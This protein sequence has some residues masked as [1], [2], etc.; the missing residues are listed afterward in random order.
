MRKAGIFESKKKVTLILFIALLALTAAAVLLAVFAMPSKDV[1]IVSAV[2]GMFVQKPEVVETIEPIPGWTPVA[3]IPRPESF[4]RPQ[5][6][7]AIYLKPGEDF[8]ISGSESAE[9]I[10]SQIDSAIAFAKEKTMNTIVIDP[11]IGGNVIYDSEIFEKTELPMDVIGYIS[12]KCIENDM[13]V[14]S[15]YYVLPDEITG[16]LVSEGQISTDLVNRIKSGADAFARSC[17]INGVLLDSYFLM[18][19]FDRYDEYLEN[20]AGIG[21]E[22]YMYN[23]SDTLFSDVVDIFS[24]VAPDMEIGLISEAVWAN[25]TENDEGSETKSSFTMFGTGHCDVKGYIEK[26]LVD[27]VSVRAYEATTSAVVPYSAV[28]DWWSGIA[29]GSGLPLYMIHAANKVGTSE[30]GWG[31]YDQLPKQIIEARRH[32][33]FSGSIFNSMTWLRNDPMESVSK[34]IDYYG[35]AI[36][37]DTILKELALTKPASLT[38]TTL[39]PIVT[40]AGASDPNVEVTLNGEPIEIDENGYFSITEDLDPGLNKFSFFNK[41]KTITYNITRKIEVLRPES[42]GPLGTVVVDGGTQVTIST[43]AYKDST[44]YAV[45][46]GIRVNLTA[47][48]FQDDST[49]TESEYRNYSGTFTAP[50][51]T[52]AEQNLGSIK[53]YGTWTWSGN[54]TATF[55]A[56]QTLGSVKV[57]KKVMLADG[58]PIVVIADAAETYPTDVIN[59]I[60]DPS[61]FPLAKG[62]IDV[63]VGNEI[64]YNDGNKTFSYYNLASGVRVYSK[65]IAPLPVDQKPGGNQI[66]GYSV[67]AD[68]RYT[69]V[70]I[71]MNQKVSYSLKYDGDAV[72]IRFNYT[73]S[74]PGSMQLNSNPLFGQA[75]WNGTTLRLQLL[76]RNVFMGYRAWYDNNGNLV[77][78]FNNPPRVSGTDLTG[79]TI[80]VDPGHGG[81][82]PGTLGFLAAY[83]EKVVNELMATELASELAARGA[84][85]VKLNTYSNNVTMEE[86]LRQAR[87]ISPH[88][89]ISLHGNSAMRSSGLGTE[90]YY[91]NNYSYDI[92]NR[93]S[94]HV[95]SAMETTN[96]GAKWGLY[97]V[98]R[99]SQFPAVLCE[100]GFLSNQGE[101]Y[102]LINQHYQVSVAQG[103][104]NAVSSYLQAM[105]PGSSATGTQ[106]YGG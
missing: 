56:E 104:A 70:T 17:D 93:M 78:Q 57:N 58:R 48:D 65:D 50:A 3:K 82:D 80:V 94:S 87:S 91:F 69:N 101:Y 86:R 100:V 11:K 13:Y 21:Y 60:S 10:M 42:S 35:G 16:K 23:I 1:W 49:N 61:F 71:S 90:V 106:T 75:D 84:N 19:K 9:E 66:T 18:D 55:S 52:E 34:L 73:D 46:G 103:I 33:G 32:E 39:E 68:G 38:F 88:L 36:R 76:R 51:A 44:V 96:R 12:Q 31:Q 15:I 45:I 29:K 41:G 30:A 74:A 20:G 22:N 98:T 81:N 72:N 89:Y 67:S 28:V 4:S 92:A 85:V 97:Y 83:S 8:F 64:L 53:L 63:A 95:A 37:P 40:F 26:G 6:M 7:R 77:F 24:Q 99:E 105:T 14:Y 102:K 54:S 59:D 27:F 43:V 79:V 2:K 47:D 62:S 5:E 25:N